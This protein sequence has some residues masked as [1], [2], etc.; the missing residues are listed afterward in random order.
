[1]VCKIDYS[2]CTSANHRNITYYFSK[3]TDYCKDTYDNGNSGFVL[4]PN[5]RKC[6]I[7]FLGQPPEE[8]HQWLAVDCVKFSLYAL[9]VYI[10]YTWSNS[11]IGLR[12]PSI[13]ERASANRC[14]S[15]HIYLYSEIPYVAD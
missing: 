2:I 9:A 10:V 8:L 4:P 1:M 14:I 5:E 6:R 11:N 15:T 3:D 12:Y 7:P 13:Q